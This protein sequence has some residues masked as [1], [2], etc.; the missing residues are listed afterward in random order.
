M[1]T[2][3]W[4]GRFSASLDPLMEAFNASLPFDKRLWQADI[5]GSQAYARALVQIGLLTEAEGSAIVDGLDQVAQE[6]AQ[7]QF[8]I[9]PNDEDIHTANERRLTELIGE[10]AGKLHTGRSRS[11]QVATGCRL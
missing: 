2:K 8:T 7:G 4:G 9:R 11:D 10:V 3:L 6:W 5:A 1:G